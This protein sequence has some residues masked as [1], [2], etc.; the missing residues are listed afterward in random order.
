MKSSIRISTLFVI[1]FSAFQVHAQSDEDQITL[2]IQSF[3]THL[4]NQDSSALRAMYMEGGMNYSIFDKAN[5]TKTFVHSPRDF[6]FNPEAILH[7]RPIEGQTQILVNGK[8]AVAWVPYTLFVNDNF[9]HCG[10]DIF[11]FIQ[12]N[13]IWKISSATYSMVTENCR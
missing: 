9:S 2:V 13:G 7:E 10:I 6:R 11:N 1:I 5:Q 4:E 8:V 3:F 12:I